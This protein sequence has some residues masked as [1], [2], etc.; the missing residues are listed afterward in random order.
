MPGLGI[1]PVSVKSSG[2]GGFG[3]KCVCKICI[4][5]KNFLK[6]T[7]LEVTFDYVDFTK[8]KKNFLI[9]KLSLLY[10]QKLFMKA[11]TKLYS[12]QY[13]AL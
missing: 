10:Q 5:G 13:S 2:G 6:F 12:T 3:F 8:G 11:N 1:F 4:G 9:A 7:K